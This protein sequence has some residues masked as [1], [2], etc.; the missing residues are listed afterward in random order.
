MALVITCGGGPHGKVI[1]FSYWRDPGAVNEYM[2]TG[3]SGRLVAFVS[4]ICFSVFAF[5][6][7]PELLVNIGGE[8]MNPRRN[9][10]QVG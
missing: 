6:F 10:P 7:A 5:V 3:D 2:K 1:G 8:M 4:T 9:L